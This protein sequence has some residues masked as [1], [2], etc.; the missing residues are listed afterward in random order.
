[1]KAAVMVT[2]KELQ[3]TQGKQKE[4]HTVRWRNKINAISWNLKG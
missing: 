4:T 3:M 1:M 2:M